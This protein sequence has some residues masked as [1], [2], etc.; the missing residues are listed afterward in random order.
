MQIA[1]LFGSVAAFV[2]RLLETCRNATI[3]LRQLEEALGRR[4]QIRLA[5]T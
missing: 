4:Y 5:P 2:R 1:D 3:P